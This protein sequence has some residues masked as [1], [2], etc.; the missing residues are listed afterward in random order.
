MQACE[1]W[2]KSNA[3]GDWKCLGKIDDIMTGF[4]KFQSSNPYLPQLSRAY[5]V[6]RCLDDCK[7]ANAIHIYNEHGAFAYIKS[8]V[9]NQ[10]APMLDAHPRRMMLAVCTAH[11]GNRY[12]LPCSYFVFELNTDPTSAP[13]D[14]SEDIPQRRM[15]F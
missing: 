3:Q 12:Y 4:T 10:L 5:P 11:T 7:F 15:H 14:T 2:F 1:Q 6:K 13:M 9:A 8:E